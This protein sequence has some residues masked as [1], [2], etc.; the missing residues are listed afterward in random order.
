MGLV[1]CVVTQ[2]AKKEKVRVFDNIN[3][4]LYTYYVYYCFAE[5]LTILHDES[6]YVS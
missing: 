2:N 1:P 3:K 6:K 5:G 4:V